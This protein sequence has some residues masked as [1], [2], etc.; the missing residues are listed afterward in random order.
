[1]NVEIK[2]QKGIWYH[3]G[4][5]DSQIKGFN[6]DRDREDNDSNAPEEFTAEHVSFVYFSNFLFQ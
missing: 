1:L 5:Q 4:E 2:L 6:Y 3:H